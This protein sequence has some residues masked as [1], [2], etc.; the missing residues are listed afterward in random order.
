MEEKERKYEDIDPAIRNL[1]EPSTVNLHHDHLFEENTELEREKRR[2][3]FK[4][5]EDRKEKEGKKERSPGRK[6]I[7]TV[8]MT[9][10]III[11]ISAS[12]YTAYKY[13]KNQPEKVDI[14]GLQMTNRH[15]YTY[16]GFEF[17]Q[18]KDGTWET[19]VYNPVTETLFI[20]SLHYGPKD[21]Y[22]L[23]IDHS[24]RDWLTYALNFDS[25]KAGKDAVG[26]AFIVFDPDAE[27][28]YHAIA[29]H[30]LARNLERG[31]RLSP[32]PALTEE[33]NVTIGNETIPV[34]S[35]GTTDEPM[36]VLVNKDPA[37]IEYNG[38][39]CI[40][41]QGLNENLVKAENRLLYQFYSVM[42]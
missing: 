13:F 21:I 25:E 20:V 17:R 38:K 35:C 29:Y 23:P 9:I 18:N 2:I 15:L 42:E 12:A 41:V 7:F 8:I 5:E 4:K 19:Q 31:L 36:I 30:E 24:A 28:G 16:N 27:G 37:R 26:A 32:H 33:T 11:G 34:K 22:D 6:K 3:E 1:G 10:L 39:N 40:F 14:P